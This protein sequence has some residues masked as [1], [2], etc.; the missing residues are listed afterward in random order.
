MLHSDLLM[1]GNLCHLTKLDQEL[2]GNMGSI[3]FVTS[4]P[5]S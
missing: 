1:K 4:T 2:K 5:Y 3:C